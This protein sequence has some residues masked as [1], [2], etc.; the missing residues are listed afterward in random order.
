MGKEK[1]L[2]NCDNENPNEYLSLLTT[3]NV[4]MANKKVYCKY[5]EKN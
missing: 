1:I 2:L 5:L 3:K 4:T